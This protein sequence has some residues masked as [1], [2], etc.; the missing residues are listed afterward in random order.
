MLC[1]VEVMKFHEWSCDLKR[2]TLR[3]E[4]VINYEVYLTDYANCID[5]FPTSFFSWVE[6]LW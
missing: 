3:K 5:F 1:R 6:K 4:N 2:G